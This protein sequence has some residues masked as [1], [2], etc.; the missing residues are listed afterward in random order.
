MPTTHTSPNSYSIIVID[1]NNGKVSAQVFTTPEAARAEFKTLTPAVNGNCFLY[2]LPVATK[3]L[4]VVTAGGF[5]TNAYGVLIDAT[6]GL[7][8]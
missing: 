8:D 6:T 1:D 2:E 3:E 7:P 4:K 5:Y